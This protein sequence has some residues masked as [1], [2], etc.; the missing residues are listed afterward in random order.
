M[1]FIQLAKFRRKVTKEDVERTNQLLLKFEKKGIKSLGG[2]FTL[3]RYDVVA[4]FDAP[5]EKVAMWVA[6]QIS[7][8]AST[9]TLVGLKR[10]DALKLLE[11]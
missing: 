8:R 10:E 5:D 11:S 2:Y 1:I 6:G 9:E 7:D 4:I 3:G